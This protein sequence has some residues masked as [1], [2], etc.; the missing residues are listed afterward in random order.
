MHQ[1]RIEGGYKLNKSKLTLVQTK[2]DSVLSYKKSQGFVH[3][4]FPR[5]LYVGTKT[6]YHLD[7]L[8][9]ILYN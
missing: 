1:L 2:S 7:L 3:I 8:L 5:W 4:Y 9:N 6:I